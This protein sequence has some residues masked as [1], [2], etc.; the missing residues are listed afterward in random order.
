MN[1][2]LFADEPILALGLRRSLDETDGLDLIGVC[3]RLENL[4]AQMELH[5][6]DI[7]LVNLTSEVTFGVLSSLRD[8]PLSPKIVLWVQAISTEL[9]LQA[10]SLGV[11]GILRRTLPV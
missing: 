9:A 10:A 4:T 11:R 2:L 7:V 6:P 1:V 8:T 5:K 3:P